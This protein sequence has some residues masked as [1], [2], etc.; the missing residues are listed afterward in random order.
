MALKAIISAKYKTI[1][2]IMGN[3]QNVII[4]IGQDAK[5]LAAPLFNYMAL[6]WMYLI[7]LNDYG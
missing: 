1:T 4:L 5:S 6:R 7:I 2:L 3:I